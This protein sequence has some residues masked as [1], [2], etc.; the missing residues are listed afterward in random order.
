[1]KNLKDTGGDPPREVPQDNILWHNDNMAIWDKVWI[2]DPATLEYVKF[3]S[4]G[5]YSTVKAM[6]QLKTATQVFGPFGGAWGL[7]SVDRQTLELPGT[8]TP[9][10]L[11]ISAD[12]Y[13]PLLDGGEGSFPISIGFPLVTNKIVTE[14]VYEKGKTVIK[15]VRNKDGKIQ[16]QLKTD[17]DAWKS[18][19]TNLVK[20]A[21]SKIGFNADLY[22]GKLDKKKSKKKNSEDEPAYADAD[23]VRQA[24]EYHE[25]LDINKLADLEK[26]I[27]EFSDVKKLVEFFHQQSWHSTNPKAKAL[28]TARGKALAP[29]KLEKAKDKDTEEAQPQAEEKTPEPKAQPKKAPSNAKAKKGFTTGDKVVDAINKCV[30]LRELKALY[31]SGPEFKEERYHKTYGI[32]KKSLI[33]LE[34]SRVNELLEAFGDLDKLEEYKKEYAS[35]FPDRFNKPEIKEVFLSKEKAL[36]TTNSDAESDPLIPVDKYANV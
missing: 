18:A 16:R 20:K 9:L 10:V 13:F 2:T 25:K 6:C 8:D 5:E 35:R 22:M 31:N 4:N 32:K 29:K 3:G 23:Y 19:E 33:S 28:F 15:P 24:S 17:L 36:S 21:L 26:R 1:M 34:V 30:T 27:A 7:R 12:F 11:V 14:K